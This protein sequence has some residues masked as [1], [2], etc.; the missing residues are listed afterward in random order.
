VREFRLYV[1]IDAKSAGGRD[2]AY[3]AKEAVAGGADIIQLRDKESTADEIVKAGRAIRAAV[4]RNKAL[5]IINDRPDIAL[6][7]DADGVHL[8]QHDLPV[9]AA[10]KIL[11][12]DKIIGLSTHS[13]EEAVAAQDS[14][15]DYI[16]V[17]PV[18]STPTKPDY[19]A[20]GLELIKK[21]K[22]VSR[23]PFVVIGGIDESNVNEVISAGASRVAVV[24]AVC[25]AKNIKE[26]AAGLKD[27]LK[28][29]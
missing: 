25:G 20:V 6:E 8:G 24:R 3:V 11:G 17:G 10:R 2:P 14:G 22:I 18:F 16:G 29:I 28:N 1:I 7:V 27:R 15:A 19:K 23:L 12:K 26:A 13:L 4:S 9:Y 5:F 21:V